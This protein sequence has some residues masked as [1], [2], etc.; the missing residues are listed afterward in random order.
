MQFDSLMLSECLGRGNVEGPQISLSA[1]HA[2]NDFPTGLHQFRTP[3]FPHV[4]P[5][6]ATG[7]SSFT[8]NGQDFVG[9][10]NHHSMLGWILDPKRLLFAFSVGKHILAR[11]P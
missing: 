9:K 10:D 1:S 2:L 4:K 5:N 3:D 7:K 8:L 6:Q 11:Q